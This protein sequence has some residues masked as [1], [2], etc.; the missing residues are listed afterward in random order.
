MAHFEKDGDRYRLTDELG[1]TA[2]FD[3][4]G[5]YELLQ[6]LYERRNEMFREL[7]G[8]PDEQIP[9]AVQAWQRAK[10][11]IE[12]LERASPFI[13][14]SDEQPA[15]PTVRMLEIRLYQPQ[16]N[17]LDELKASLPT[18]HEQY[19]APECRETGGPVKVLSVK[20]GEL[21]QDALA[22]LNR[23]QLDYR[24]FDELVPMAD[25]DE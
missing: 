25:E 4:Q 18:L 1:Q 8:L 15:V 5:A 14:D 13:P 3:T 12:A 10:P 19:E 23:L 17:H 11:Q 22:L 20:Y 24:T 6:W 9:E 2:Y 7:H 21:S 16:W